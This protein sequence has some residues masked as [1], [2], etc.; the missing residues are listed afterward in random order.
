MRLK[1]ALLI[2]FGIVA[3][4]LFSTGVAMAQGK[5]PKHA[6]PSLVGAWFGIARPCPADSA[7]D[8]PQHVAFC[9][10]V[11]GTCTSI[12]GTLPPELP[13]M[14]TFSADGAL[15]VDDAGEMGRYHTTAHGTWGLS[16]DD[17]LPDWQGLERARATFLWLGSTATAT[18]PF[19]TCCFSNAVRTRT[20]TYSD[21]NDPDRILGYIQ[22]YATLP[23]V[24]AK[25]NMLV[26]PSNPS[27]PTA[28]NHIP[29]SLS[30]VEPLPAGCANNL[31]CLGTY[32]F[33][34]QRIKSQ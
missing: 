9:Q 12:P 31:G 15:S 10:A 4:A 28:G 13:L 32:H 29:Q 26:A 22:P 24:D 8:S 5:S 23:A 3:V 25:G 2:G 33:V 1:Q 17:S 19:G 30:V 14:A 34:I 21:P 18:E 20:V 6:E 27:D 7:T 11:C 16:T